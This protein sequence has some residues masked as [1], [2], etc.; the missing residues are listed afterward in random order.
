[1]FVLWYVVCVVSHMDWSRD[2]VRR[3]TRSVLT[4]CAQRI[5]TS[6]SVEVLF[7]CLFYFSLVH[8]D[9]SSF[10][11]L[12]PGADADMMFPTFIFVLIRFLRTTGER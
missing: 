3:N 12:K 4:S 5:Q 2:G 10:G 7:L 1:M 9:A 6:S 11:L 8:P